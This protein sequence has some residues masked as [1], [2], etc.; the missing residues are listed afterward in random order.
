LRFR[1]AFVDAVFGRVLT[2]WVPGPHPQPTRKSFGEY[3]AENFHITVS[4]NYCA[5]AF[6][7]SLQVIGAD[8]I[9]FSTDWPFENVDYSARWFDELEISEA[10]R[11]KIGRLNA[12]KLF[13]LDLA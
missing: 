2:A 9:L 8:R 6:L 10:D 4:G 5:Q 12:A 3:F 11:H 7:C 1:A 13:N